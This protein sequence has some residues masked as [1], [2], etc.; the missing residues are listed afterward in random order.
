MKYI[1]K[2]GTDMKSKYLTVKDMMIGLENFFDIV[3]E[4]NKIVDVTLEGNT[5]AIT[6]KDGRQFKINDTIWFFNEK[7]QEWE[8]LYD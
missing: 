2:R 6:L 4:Y 7:T 8:D 5:L 1:S 3:G